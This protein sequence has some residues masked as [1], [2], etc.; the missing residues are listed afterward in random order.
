MLSIFF[1]TLANC[2]LEEEQEE[3]ES[4]LYSPP[5]LSDF[6]TARQQRNITLTGKKELE[7]INGRYFRKPLVNLIQSGAPSYISFRRL[8]FDSFDG[9]I[10][11]GESNCLAK[12]PDIVI[13]DSTFS[14]SNQHPI[15]I[16]GPRENERALEPDFGGLL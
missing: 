6:L 11:K 3:D 5:V 15:H 1:A 14:K 12:F 10:L 9:I 13:T 2:H 4:R 16:N 7:P 8:F